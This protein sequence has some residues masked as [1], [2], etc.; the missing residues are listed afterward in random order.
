MKR[1]ASLPQKL[2]FYL[3]GGPYRLLRLVF[4]ELRQGNIDALRGL[5]HGLVGRRER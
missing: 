3:V 2:G 1:H 4:R 5:T